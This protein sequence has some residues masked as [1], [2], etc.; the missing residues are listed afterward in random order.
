MKLIVGLG[1]PGQQYRN[2]RHNVGFRVLDE[3]AVRLGVRFDQEKYDGLLAIASHEGERLML[4]KPLTYMN[5]SGTS[6]AKAARNRVPEPENVLVVLDEIQ[7]PLG[8]V[9]IREKGSHGG[10]NGLRS[11]VEHLGTQ[12][13]PRLRIGVGEKKADQD[14]SDHV[15]S[16]F[17]PEEKPDVER[18]LA[19]AA[20]AVLCC[21]TDGVAA[22]MNRFNKAK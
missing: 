13:F 16:T 22:A 15:L 14:L 5:L 8:T 17:A 18:A 7:L 19:L 3:V 10:H 9:R 20:D 21:V 4:L 12:E 2:T 11:V 1:N 6:V